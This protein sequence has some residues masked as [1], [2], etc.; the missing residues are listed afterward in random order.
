MTSSEPLIESKLSEIISEL[1]TTAP[2]TTPPLK[3]RLISICTELETQRA[4]VQTLQAK[5]EQQQTLLELS[6]QQQDL[7]ADVY[8]NAAL[9]QAMRLLHAS[10]G[11]CAMLDPQL[12][13]EKL[14]QRCLEIPP[15]YSLYD[16]PIAEELLQRAIDEQRPIFA[17]SRLDQST[18]VCIPLI[19]NGELQGMIY[20][21]GDSELATGFEQRFLVDGLSRTLGCSLYQSRVQTTELFRKELLITMAREI[22]APMSVIDSLSE[23]LAQSPPAPNEIREIGYDL[24]AT[25]RRISHLVVDAIEICDGSPQQE[26]EPQL[27][28]LQQELTQHLKAFYII[29]Q[30]HDCQI[31]LHNTEEPCQIETLPKRL[32]WVLN[33]IIHSFLRILSPQSTLQIWFSSRND[34]GPEIALHR[35]LDESAP[36]FLDLGELH[37]QENCRFIEINFQNREL[38]L[39]P[40]MLDKLFQPFR[41]ALLET[42]PTIH[43][44]CQGLTLA[45]QCARTLGGCIW[46]TSNPQMGTHC[47]FTVPTHVITRLDDARSLWQ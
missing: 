16:L 2:W 35:P 17:Q 14:A 42:N 47:H 29:A 41:Q 10:C 32:K 11:F 13:I 26:A 8:L 36:L 31:K 40:P 45:A 39:S 3:D 6:W 43:D 1:S 27:I 30:S 37:P 38:Q 22:C 4:S 23:E 33:H 44:L 34:A 28:D 19:C 7:N 25:A 18:A 5:I 21:E 46:V 12:R 20:L 24:T 9:N 15:S